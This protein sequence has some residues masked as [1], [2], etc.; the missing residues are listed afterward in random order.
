MC[1][2]LTLRSVYPADSNESSSPAFTPPVKNGR[3][4]MLGENHARP[5][6]DEYLQVWYLPFL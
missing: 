4:R 3:A 6:G 2:F 5:R 1:P